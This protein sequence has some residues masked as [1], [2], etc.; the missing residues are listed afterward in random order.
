MPHRPVANETIDEAW[1]RLQESNPAYARFA[2]WNQS[3]TNYLNGLAS[4]LSEDLGKVEDEDDFDLVGPIPRR[5][6]SFQEIF[7]WIGDHEYPEQWAGVEWVLAELELQFRAKHGAPR[8]T[9]ILANEVVAVHDL[10]TR[11][12]RW[13]EVT[14]RANT[15]AI[16]DFADETAMRAV[17]DLL[18]EYPAL[19]A[20]AYSRVDRE[21]P[22]GM[23]YYHVVY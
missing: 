12:E 11:F 14:Q 21:S 2:G 16:F 3:L 18:Y 10:M 7:D 13:Y 23:N 15:A 1:K 22:Q 6:T 4:A 9:P 19:A 8:S 20:Y 17:L 5:L